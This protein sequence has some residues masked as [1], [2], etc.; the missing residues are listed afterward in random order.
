[1]ARAFVRSEAEKVVK[2]TLTVMGGEVSFADLKARLQA[3]GNG[4][5]VGDILNLHLAGKLAGGTRS[6]PDSKPVL[7]LRAEAAQAA[8]T[9]PAPTTAPSTPSGT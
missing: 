5:Y 4:Q 8:P 7:F 6:V 1:M 9:A 3:D 2:D